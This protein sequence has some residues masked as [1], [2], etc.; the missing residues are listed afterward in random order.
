MIYYFFVNHRCK[1]IY[2]SNAQDAMEDIEMNGEKM[3][4][5]AE[6]DEWEPDDII[7]IIEITF[8]EF[9]R[10]IDFEPKESWEKLIRLVHEL[11]YETCC[12]FS[13]E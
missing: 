8:D 5:Y 6:F 1:A 7:E 2:D 13:I 9:D 10:R 12:S 4:V 11:K 3:G